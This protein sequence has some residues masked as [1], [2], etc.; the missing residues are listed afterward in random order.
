MRKETD[1]F[2]MH[3]CNICQYRTVKSLDLLGF[4]LCPSS[5]ILSLI[6]HHQNPLE[7]TY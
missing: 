5:G 7:S 6:H 3:K 2:I 1:K 4:G